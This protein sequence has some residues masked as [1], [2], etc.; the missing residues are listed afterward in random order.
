MKKLDYFDK[1]S[2]DELR[3]YLDSKFAEIEK[4]SGVL[5]SLGILSF[6]STKADGKIKMIISDGK[7]PDVYYRY[8]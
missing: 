2:F 4:E 5:L 1:K 7:D 8:M 3:K 6:N